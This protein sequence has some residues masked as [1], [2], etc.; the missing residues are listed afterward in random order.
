MAHAFLNSDRQKRQ[1][2][3]QQRSQD[4]RHDKTGIAAA[5]SGWCGA[6]FSSGVTAC[7]RSTEKLRQPQ[8]GDHITE[9]E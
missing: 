2:P 6:V 1:S 5:L 8:Q 9:A 4:Q 3:S 7:N